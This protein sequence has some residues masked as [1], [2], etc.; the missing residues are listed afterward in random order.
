MKPAEVH[1]VLREIN[2]DY[3]Y[4]ANSVATSCTFLERC[5][6]LSR[7][8]AEDHN[9]VQTP[10]NSDG[11]DK[12]YGIWHSIFL[13]HVD[14]HYRGGR[15]KG[16]NQYG[17]VLF[18]FDVNIL[19][20]LPKGV[21]ISV[22]KKNPVNWIEKEPREKQWFLSSEELAAHISF[23]DFDKMLVINTASGILNFPNQRL[24]ILLDDPKRKLSSGEDAYVYAEKRL[25]DAAAAGNVNLT[26]NSHPCR[27]DCSCIEKY[28]LYTPKR[29]DLLFG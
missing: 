11:I 20:T 7:G 24:K 17:P 18:V 19:T 3:I 14:I 23:G 5:A 12:K 25:R 6:L 2:A 15:T 16:P 21:D 28:A 13:D 10:Q 1:Q 26:I 9:L 29:F 8:Y 22:T 4:H 27:S